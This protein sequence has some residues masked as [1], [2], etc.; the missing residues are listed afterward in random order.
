VADADLDG[1]LWEVVVA[2]SDRGMSELRSVLRTDLF[3]AAAAALSASRELI[4][5]GTGF[6]IQGQP[7]TDGPP[8]AFALADALAALGK[9]VMIATWPEAAEIFAQVRADLHFLGVERDEASVRYFEANH[10]FVAIEIC[11]K[12]GDGSY[13]NMRHEDISGQ[14]PKFEAM[15][16]T[17]ALIGIGDGGNEFGMGNLPDDFVER[18]ALCK[19]VATCDHL[20][21]GATSNFA[22]YALVAALERSSGH[23]LLPDPSAHLSVIRELVRAGCVDGITGKRHEKVDGLPLKKTEQVLAE[24]KQ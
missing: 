14:T 20:L 9:T 22:T 7:E 17:K 13:R 12:C 21:P 5:I 18:W 16:G 19:P 11:G 15:F 8:G 4:I 1:R 23:R 6:P 2:T 10:T 24:L 3:T